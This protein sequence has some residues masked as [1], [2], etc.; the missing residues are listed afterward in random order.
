VF[1]DEAQITVIS[2]DGGSGCVSFRR[3]KYVP[4]GGPDGGDGGNGGSVIMQVDPHLRTLLDFRHR[5]IF[6]AERGQHGMGKQCSGKTAPDLVVRVPR[7]T[8]VLDALTGAT[9]GDLTE[10]GQKVVVAKGGHG[11]RGNQ[12]F[13]TAT[14]Q[15]PREHEPGW[16]GET[17]E[18]KLVLKL[19]ADV[20][21]VGFPNAGK[22]TLLSRVSAA[23]PKVAEYPFTTLTPHLGIVKIGGADDTRSLVMADIPG[24]IEGASAGKGLGHQFLKHIERTRILLILIDVT[25]EDP[26]GQEATLLKEMAGYSPAL[27]DK[28]R[29]TA[30]TKMDLLPPGSPLPSLGPGREKL[31]AISAHTGQ[32][33]EQLLSELDRRLTALNST[34]HSE[35]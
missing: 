4:K 17:K 1:I 34:V 14:H 31:P 13:A 7:G 24:L 10:A 19:I 32:G 2:G 15:A 23:R 21:L 25:A 35:R 16:P 28:P 30:F 22:S 20:G 11:G 33:M 27:L 6:K 3:E 18:I 8:M 29:I 5:Q 9:I 12:H 26:A